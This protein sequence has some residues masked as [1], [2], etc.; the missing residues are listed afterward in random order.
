VNEKKKATIRTL[1][2]KV[3]VTQ[4]IGSFQ[5]PS[6]KQRVQSQERFQ[7]LKA[8]LEHCCLKCSF[9]SCNQSER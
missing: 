1:E 3:K 8:Y 6:E 9:C 4:Q 2:G 5:Y 7:E